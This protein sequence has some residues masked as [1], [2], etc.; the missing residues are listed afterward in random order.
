[1]TRWPNGLLALALAGCM[2]TPPEPAKPP[3][4][5]AASATP[6]PKPAS[7]TLSIEGIGGPTLAFDIAVAEGEAQDLV[8]EV[9]VRCWLD[10]VI[11]GAALLYDEETGR[12]IM[13]SDTSDLLAADFLSAE[14]DATTVQLTGPVLEDL[15]TR[16]RVLET[17][18]LAV[19]TGETSCAV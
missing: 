11:G 8:R 9:A 17:L 5:P 2:T 15:A 12:M 6:E 19:A 18:E 4:A 14:P 13:V 16:V 10:H 7:P 1:M 3:A